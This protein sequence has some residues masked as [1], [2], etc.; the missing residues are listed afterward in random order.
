MARPQRNNVDY[1]PLYVDRGH[2][3]YVIE[4]KYG[5]NGFA[6]WIKILSELGKADF[7][8]LDLREESKLMYLAAICLVTESELIKIIDDLVRLKQFDLELWEQRILFSEKFCDSIADAYAKR[9]GEAPSKECLLS[10]FPSFRTG[11][12]SLGSDQ[13]LKDSIEE[14][15]IEK[16]IKKRDAELKDFYNTSC[17]DLSTCLKISNGR[18]QSIQ[19]RIDEYGIDKVKEAI[20]KAGKSDFL[21][22]ANVKNW[23]ASFDWVINPNNFLKILEG[24]YDNAVKKES[25]H[26]QLEEA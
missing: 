19:A 1:F 13:P 8:F 21:K 14:N 3:V 12:P 25:R 23:K 15:S 24:N 26:K 4:Q 10:L 11:N 9:E 16:D 17:P 22:G 2:K 20:T 18:A 7:H 6:T 5:N